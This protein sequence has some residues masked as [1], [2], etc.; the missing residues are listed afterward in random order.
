MNR[1]RV[2]FGIELCFIY[3][4]SVA[5]LCAVLTLVHPELSILSYIAYSHK[6]SGG[7]RVKTRQP[8][9]LVLICTLC[10]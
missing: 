10:L 9:I 5:V 6:V 1:C 2:V 8:D 3:A 4:V 7:L